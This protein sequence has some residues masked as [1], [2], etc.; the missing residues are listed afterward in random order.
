MANTKKVVGVLSL[1][2]ISLIIVNTAN[3]DLSDLLYSVSV[4]NDK[5]RPGENLEYNVTLKNEGSQE[6]PISLNLLFTGYAK[7]TPSSFT[8]E[9][10]ETKVVHV[11]LTVKPEQKPGK[12]IVKLLVFSNGESLDSPIPLQGE[13]LESMAAYSNVKIL[14]VEFPKEIDLRNPFS[15]N[16]TI[17]NPVKTVNATLEIDADFENDEQIIQHPQTITIPEG[18]NEITVENISFPLSVSSGNHSI[19]IRIRFAED[20]FTQSTIQTNV[21]GFSECETKEDVNVSIFGKTY[22]ATVVNLGNVAT[23]CKVDTKISKIEKLLLVSAS[24]GYKIE[25]NKIK[26]EVKL[27]PRTKAV[28]EFKVNY[29]PLLIIPFILIAIAIAI[30][31]L[32]RKIDVKKE[33]VSHKRHPSFLDLKIQIKIRNLTNKELKRVKITE[34]LPAFVKEVRD[35]GTVPGRVVKKGKQ[36]VITWEIEKLNP[37]E[38]RVLSYTIRTSIVVLGNIIFPPTKVEFRDDKMIRE[39]ASNALTIQ[40]E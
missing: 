36:K 11:S 32:T 7:I 22:K 37:K 17:D 31:Y 6:L 4:I 40:I 39:E 14:S 13:I 5:A 29:T 33:L 20:I 26:W 19:T 12:I 18:T 2:L 30:W 1:L 15:F 38:E 3:A 34:P 24:E 8:L 21:L 16:M 10:G 9:P 27:E 35:Y 25:N 28:V 23:I